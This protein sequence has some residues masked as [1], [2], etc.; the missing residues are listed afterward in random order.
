[1]TYIKVILCFFNKSFLITNC[2]FIDS[3]NC[4]RWSPSGDMIASASADKTVA[5]MDFKTGI[6]IYTGNTSCKSKFSPEKIATTT[7]DLGE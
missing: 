1:M 7:K 4:V 5:L 6:N 2:Y 3:I